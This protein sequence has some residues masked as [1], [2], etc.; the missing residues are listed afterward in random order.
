MFR[1][2]T[3]TEPYEHG[4][5]DVASNLAFVRVVITRYTRNGETDSSM[6]DEDRL[7]AIARNEIRRVRDIGR[8]RMSVL[9]NA[10]VVA[11][12]AKLK[13]LSTDRTE[14]GLAAP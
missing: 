3:V 10:S 4:R 14:R 1:N 5:G 11:M 2:T 13:V 9:A 7:A 8:R 6:V 12:P